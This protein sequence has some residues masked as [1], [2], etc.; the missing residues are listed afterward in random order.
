[1]LLSVAL[2][3]VACESN[4][5]T[6]NTESGIEVTQT[7][8]PHEDTIDKSAEPAAETRSVEGTVT[9]INRGKDGYTAKL[10][11]SD[12]QFYYVTIS[13][14]NLKDH[15]QYK[16]VKIGDKLN[17]TGDYWKLEAEQQIT[18]RQIN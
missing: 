17:V 16:E 6:T 8:T 4:K 2:A 15:T 18:V 12:K 1:M 9:E 5:K 3:T 10:E 11:T 13:H 14:S 7:R